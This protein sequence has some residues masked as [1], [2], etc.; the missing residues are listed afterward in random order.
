LLPATEACDWLPDEIPVLVPSSLDEPEPEPELD[1]P[2][3]E[4]SELLVAVE[5]GVAADE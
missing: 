3:P 5:L 2:E 1:E 4:S